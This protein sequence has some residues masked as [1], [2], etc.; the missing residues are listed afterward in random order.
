M[1]LTPL[2]TPL[3][4]GP[5]PTYRLDTA[6]RLR[7]AT[8]KYP[9]AHAVPHSAQHDR[10]GG[11]SPQHSPVRVYDPAQGLL[12]YHGQP[13]QQAINTPT[14]HPGGVKPTVPPIRRIVP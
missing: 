7:I 1:S 12:R 2:P 13:Q 11:V 4:Q 14:G 10:P 6:T 5:W 9:V 3:E 8:G